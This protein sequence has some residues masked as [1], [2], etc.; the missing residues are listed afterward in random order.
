MYDK[1]M[2]DGSWMPKRERPTVDCRYDMETGE[3]I[4]SM[5]KQE[6]RDDCD[7]N[8]LMARYEKTG[9]IDHINRSVPQY[10]DF[11][12]VPEYHEAIEIVRRAESDFASLPATVRDRFENDPAQYLAFVNDPENLEE[13]YELGLRERPKDPEPQK[14]EI[15]GGAVPQPPSPPEP[16]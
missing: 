10:G 12:S 14:V 11:A 7:I 9:V 1:V 3:E 16:K 6:F 15:V 5:T 8:L 2:D 4:P 13:S